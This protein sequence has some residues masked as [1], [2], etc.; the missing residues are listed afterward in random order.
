M[1]N[2]IKTQGS[3]LWFIDTTGTPALV[4]LTCPTGI[5]GVTSGARDQIETTC[6]DETDTRTYISG[7]N[8]ASA[9]SVPFV[10]QDPDASH[11]SIFTLKETG[12]VLNWLAVGGNG[13]AAP[14]LTGSTITPP[15]TRTSVSFS[16][17]ISEVALEVGGND[18]WRGTLTIQRTGPAVPHWKT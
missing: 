14:T 6:L 17:Y 18:V 10:V 13:T 12:A 11:K 1:A 5:T 4:K 16:G 2:E 8:G 3:S 15:T 9:I 7:L